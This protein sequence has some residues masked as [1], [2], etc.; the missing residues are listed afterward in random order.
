MSP[1][2]SVLLEGFVQ[3]KNR[4]VL[5][6]M[7]WYQDA[8]WPWVPWGLT[9]HPDFLLYKS[10][11]ESNA[12]PWFKLSVFSEAEWAGN[13]QMR[14]PCCKRKLIGIQSTPASS[15]SP[16]TVAPSNWNFS[17][18]LWQKQREPNGFSDQRAHQHCADK[19]YF[20]ALNCSSK[21]NLAKKMEQEDLTCSW[22][23]LKTGGFN[24]DLAHEAPWVKHT[25]SA[26]PL[27]RKQISQDYHSMFN[28]RVSTSHCAH[29]VVSVPSS[30]SP[31]SVL[32]AGEVTLRL[33]IRYNP[34][35]LG[36]GSA[37]RA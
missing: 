2:I 11:A 16:R 24:D 19:P 21:H 23:W 12:G 15:A 18:R 9:D 5:T 37:G 36:K 26:A 27:T 13:E 34:R 32:T 10:H 25:L 8:G 29:S 30:A 7:N 35:S 4:T 1:L 14:T 22:L 3:Y 20:M 17:C 31:C 6:M 28:S 33:K